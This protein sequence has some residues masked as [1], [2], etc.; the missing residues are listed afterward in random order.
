MNSKM[1]VVT[2]EKFN[3]MDWAGK[4]KIVLDEG[5]LVSI[6]DSPKLLNSSKVDRLYVY[7]DANQIKT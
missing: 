1:R 4:Q 6:Y 2:L 5:S 3:N 7:G